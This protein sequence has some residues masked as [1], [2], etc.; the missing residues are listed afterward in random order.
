MIPFRLILSV[1]LSIIFLFGSLPACVQTAPPDSLEAIDSLD[2]RL[3]D[4]KGAEFSPE[5]YARFINHWVAAKGRLLSEEDVIR[6]PWEPNR[7]A[8]DLQKIREEGEVALSLALERQDAERLNAESR[9][10]MV[11]ERFRLFD[12]HVHDMG[13]RIM[14]GQKPIETELLV[15]QARSFL[16]HGLFFRS[17]QA[18]RQASLMMDD[19]AA[20]LANELGHYADERTIQTWR[21][22]ANHAVEWSRRHRTAAIVVSKADRRLILYRSGGQVASYPVQLGFNGVLDKRY[23]DEGATPVGHYR[24]I[25]KRGRGQTPFYRAFLL[26]YPHT[27]NRRHFQPGRPLGAIPVDRTTGGQIEIHSSDEALSIQTPGGI[28]LENRHIDALFQRVGV[29]T[30]VTIVGAMRRIN[31]IALALAEL[32]NSEES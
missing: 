17:N 31:S 2:R 7:L 15:R 3:T 28:M 14:L 27:E 25:R 19:Q 12:D 30:P 29:G 26:D 4:V 16:E 21:R 8:A 22:M 6:L 1:T 10:A 5:E 24:V 11:E 13:S 9:L 18:V 32:E 23:Q 20:I